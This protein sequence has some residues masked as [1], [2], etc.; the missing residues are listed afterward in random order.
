MVKGS[1]SI[2]PAEELVSAAMAAGETQIPEWCG[3]GERR[4]WTQEGV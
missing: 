1:Q 3:D 2:W 4:G